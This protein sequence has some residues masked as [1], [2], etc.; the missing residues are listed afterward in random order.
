MLFDSQVP[1]S[2]QAPLLKVLDLLKQ[3]RALISQKFKIL[4]KIVTLIDRV[5]ST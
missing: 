4:D 2:E 5:S 3:K 1:V